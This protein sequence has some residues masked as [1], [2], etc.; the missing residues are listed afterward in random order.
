MAEALAALPPGF[1]LDAP[2]PPGFELDKPARART[3]SGALEALQAGYEGSAT[4]LFVRGR[5]PDVVLDSTHSKWYEKAL[6]STAQVVSEI[7]EM[8][9]GGSFG[10]ALGTVV[11]SPAGP[12]GAVAG[13]VIGTGAGAFAAPALIRETLMQAY[14]KG[15]VSSLADFLTRTSIVLKTGGKEALVGGLTFG[16]GGVAAR[17]VGSAVAPLVGETIS[18]GTA[19]A[20]IGTGQTLAELGTMVVAPAALEGKLPEPEDFLN[21]AIVIVG[22]KASVGVAGKI[23]DVYAKT[24]IPPE[25]VVADAKADPKIAEELK[26]E[27]GAV[28]EAY[29]PAARAENARAA[30][31]G[32]KAADV[33]QSPFAEL[34]Q[35]PGEPARPTHVNYDYVNTADDVKGAMSRLSMV[36]EAEIQGQRRGTVTWEETSAEA[37]RI[38][39]DTLGGVDTKLIMP[40]EPG[41]PAGAAEILARKQMVVGAAE[42]MAAR[43]RE[44]AAKGKENVTPEDTAKF[45]ASIERAAMIQS[46]FLGARAEAGR[47][48]NILKS[49]AVD[50]ERAKQIRD[51]IDQYGG[52][53]EELARM[54]GEIDNPAGMM[55]F[56][57]RTTKATT[58]QQV[59]EAWKAGLVSGLITQVTNGLGNTTFL[60]LRPVIDTVAAGIGLFRSGPDR[61]TAAEPLARLAGNLHGTMD[62][63][64]VALA[65]LRTGEYDVGKAETHR[66]AIPGVAGEVVRLPFRGLAA[67]DA[68]FR[69]MNER[70]EAWSLAMREASNEGL[71]FA[72]REFRERAA[73][74]AQ[75]PTLKMAE[76]IA[77]AGERFTFNSPLGEKGRAVQ[78]F[79]NSW[80]LEWLVPFIRTPG[81]VAKELARLT[82]LSPLVGEWR[83]DLAKGGA[84]ADKAMAEVIVGSAIGS[85]AMS[86]AFAGHI[87]GA[88]D[89]DPNKRRVQQAA[90]WQPYSVKV[91]G[92]WY[93]YQRLQPIGTLIGLASDIAGVW[94]HLTPE[95]SDKVP[96]MLSVAFANAVTN[97]TFLQGITN[98]VN[99]ISDPKR[100]GPKFVQGLVGSAVPAIA[101]QTAQVN[102]PYVREINS[103]VDAV[104]NRVPGL[105]ETLFPKRDPFGEKVE[106]RDRVAWV[107]P[108]T[109]I[110]ESSDSVRSEAARLGVGVA[111]TPDSITLPSGHDRK[112]G[113][114]KLTPEQQDVFADTAG[115]IAYNV[116]NPVV[117]SA[118]WDA[119]P[120]M[121]KKRMYEVTFERA[122][123]AGR[124]AALTTAQRHQEAERIRD[125]LRVRLGQ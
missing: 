38:L 10:G 70:G 47:A 3:A 31:P 80:H 15:E 27:G 84:A 2:P 75:N 53:P 119:L 63:L 46:E 116:L 21:A 49:T 81:N 44:Y 57:K 48:L 76:A 54:L 23:R 65:V 51:V 113:E 34:P 88:G 7:P 112:L 105:R 118:S 73:Q 61:V 97:Q 102:D 19:R 17:S 14:S 67:M 35:A 96:K 60:G 42:D 89:P 52:K 125:E 13:N 9:I 92:T 108:I 104:K 123:A 20:A 124:A 66:K 101:A 82:P 36:Y 30:V 18:A 50:A 110:G 98:I 117:N 62:G 11:G 40:R 43:A 77:D 5:L 78:Q 33:A 106:N 109:T 26:S 25:Q 122:R 90:G 41:T 111:K 91:N 95:E 39:A 24:G 55:E 83:A 32:E 86:L 114:V 8:V 22:A 69:T 16:V 71:S 45:L 99:A 6:A 85:A 94:D 93:S 79:V 1:E 29:V 12:G 72:S 58:W 4:G 28:P 107:S 64:K 100:F 59:V 37:G 56:A 74:F 120:D 103:V 115:H 87:S 121:V 68:L